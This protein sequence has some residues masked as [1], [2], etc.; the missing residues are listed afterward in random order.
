MRTPTEDIEI[1]RFFVV[2]AA[3]AT[4]AILVAG[5]FILRGRRPFVPRFGAD[6]RRLVSAERIG[7]TLEVLAKSPHRTGTPANAAAADEIARRLT[8]AGL[9][10]WSDVHEVELW[11]PEALS[12]ALTKPV[13]RTFDLHERALPEDPATAV[14]NEELPFLAYAPDADVEAP[15]VYA[16]FGAP[17]DFA[18]LRKAGVDARGK[19][20]LVKAQGVCLGMKSLAAER[21]GA[22]GLLVYFEPR[23]Q[24]DAKAPN[25]PGPPTNRWAAPRGTLL[26]HFLRPGDPRRAKAAGVDTQPK[27]PALAISQDVAEAL[28]KEIGGPAPPA[29]WKGLLEAPYTLG[30]G[31]ARARMTVRGKTSRASLRNVLATIS[32]GDPKGAPVVLGSH[33]DAWVYGAV[34]PSSGTAAVLEVA[35]VLARLADRGW[36]PSRPI[37]FAFFDGE[38]FGMLGSTRWFET[39]LAGAD[40]PALAFLVVD[41]AVRANAFHAG[42]TPGLR[43]PLAEALALVD[44]PDSGKPLQG[45]PGEPALPGFSNDA[46]PFLGFS[47]T[48]V[49]ELGFGRWTGG[50]HTLY[51]TATWLTRFG[52]PGFRRTAALARVAAL[53]VGMLATPRFFPLRFTELSDFTN[54]EIREIQGRNPA[55]IGWVPQAARSLSRQIEGFEAGARAWDAR[56]RASRGPGKDAGRFDR[57]VSL[58]LNAFGAPGESFGR[59]CRLWG[60]SPETGCGA[61]GLP[62]LE[63]AVRRGD[64]VAAGK[65]IDRLAAAFS[66]AR[67]QLVVA[68]LLADGGRP[69]ARPASG[70]ARRP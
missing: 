47:A 7:E 41:S 58:A 1:R 59:G 48:P 34:D 5:F 31:P 16:G 9:K 42:T 32:G 69:L 68:N 63:E 3:I 12:L 46:A 64:R 54:R 43:G 18:V 62:A 49:A 56:T 33:I 39:R 27:I 57:N 26:K 60:P 61:A 65:E 50:S 51:D 25:P 24:S 6:V 22:V 44:D 15:I 8:A 23:D 66:R 28:L 70:G 40:L 17:A 55:S 13:A 35:T 14:A 2:A 36:T 21:A 29:D 52:D 30:P 37:V 19:I 4:L 11:E 38:E 67:E 20:A 10:P 45:S 53:Y